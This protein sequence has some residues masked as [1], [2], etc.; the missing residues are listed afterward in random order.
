MVP[1]FASAQGD[2]RATPDSLFLPPHGDERVASLKL[3]WEA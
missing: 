1:N 2:V 3:S